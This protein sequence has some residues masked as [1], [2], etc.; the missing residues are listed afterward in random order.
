MS[1]EWWDS[2]PPE[3]LI[4]EEMLDFIE[5][6]NNRDLEKQM[7]KQGD[8]LLSRKI[9]IEKQL[10]HNYQ[11]VKMTI[12]TTDHLLEDDTNL[13]DDYLQ[14]EIGKY[15]DGTLGMSDAPKKKTWDNKK[16]W[17][18]KTNDPLPFAP[19]NNVSFNG[20]YEAFRR[21]KGFG[22]VGQWKFLKEKK[23]IDISAVRDYDDLQA[24]FKQ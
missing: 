12:E 5:S 22:S 3:D 16:S 18:D 6:A 10:S 11:T 4:D 14:G 24:R 15:T 1:K 19:D 9:I 21:A 2:V 8:T 23:N 17:D 20:D 7:N 13:L